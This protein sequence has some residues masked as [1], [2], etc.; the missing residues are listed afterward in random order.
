LKLNAVTVLSVALVAAA[1]PSRSEPTFAARSQPSSI[2][3][4]RVSVDLPDYVPVINY[5]QF[6][7]ASRADDAS[8]SDGISTQ[9]RSA[10]EAL[11]AK[12]AGSSASLKSQLARAAAQ[13]D[14]V[15]PSIVEAPEDPKSRMQVASLQNTNDVG[16]SAEAEKEPTAAS[17]ARQKA[18]TKSAVRRGPRTTRHAAA[19]T[20]KRRVVQHRSNRVASSATSQRSG[21]TYSGIGADLQRLIG[22]GSLTP[23]HRMTN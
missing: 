20:R 21:S 19:A 9:A 11:S 1:L 2:V 18:E 14:P 5:D 15:A 7:L 8:D 4:H 13:P 6:L 17:E 16:M 22:F 12:F 23:D 3:G 10:A